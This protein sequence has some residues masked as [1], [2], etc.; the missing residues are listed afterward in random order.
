MTVRVTGNTFDHRE[1]LKQL[2]G[3]WD[4]A[5]KNWVFDYASPKDVAELKNLPGC[6]VIGGD[7]KPQQII[8]ITNPYRLLHDKDFPHLS[9][10]I[11]IGDDMTYYNYFKTQNP[12]VF[13]GFS[14]FDKFI[15]HVESLKR[16]ENKN[17]LCDVGWTVENNYAGTHSMEEAIN[18]AKNGWLDGLGIMDLLTAQS[19][20]G[21]RKIKSVSG[22]NVNVGRLISGLP[23]HM[24]K[25]VKA[26]NKKIITL[27]VETV[28]WQGIKAHL[29]MVRTV[30]IAAMVDR[31]EAEGYQ[32]NIVAVYCALHRK[33]SRGIQTAVNIKQAGER[34]NLADVS[35]AFGHPSF[36]R[37][38]VYAVEG[39]VSQC[40]LTTELRG[41]VDQAFDENHLPGRNEFYIPQLRG[42][43]KTLLHEMIE[44]LQ[45]ENLPVKIKAE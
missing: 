41:I 24:N 44:I 40:S 37:R 11:K 3:R 16:P 1:R 32:C 22:G 9:E 29:A 15:L 5:A 2:G 13:F 14:T 17:G 38:F 33:T 27:F 42:N 45:P 4:P 30:I 6:L 36:G 8:G 19:P 28:M 35:F 26:P 43:E 10:P 12:I 18:L 31:L 25:R 34:L 39:C 20:I 21:K 23:N 7:D